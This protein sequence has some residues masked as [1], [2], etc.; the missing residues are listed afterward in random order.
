MAT[1]TGSRRSVR[2]ATRG[3]RRSKRV[4]TRKLVLGSNTNTAPIISQAASKL[5][6]SI[7][8]TSKSKS[9]KSR[10]SKSSKA[11]V[12]SRT[13]GSASPP[14][15]PVFRLMDLPLELRRL[16]YR[17]ALALDGTT[18]LQIC[19]Q[20]KHEGS[21]FVYRSTYLRFLG[22]C[23][24][25]LSGQIP[26]NLTIIALE[27]IQ[28]I[29]ITIDPGQLWSYRTIPLSGWRYAS[30]ACPFVGSNTHCRQNCNITIGNNFGHSLVPIERIP[31]VLDVLVD[32]KGFRHL[33][34]TVI[35]GS[36]PKSRRGPS[37]PESR[38]GPRVPESRWVPGSPVYPYWAKNRKEVY[39]MARARFAANYGPGVW[40]GNARPEH[41]YL[42][43]HPR[44][45][46]MALAAGDVQKQS[47][48]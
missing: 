32:F 41:S 23:Q 30:V 16:I 7:S 28:N 44:A 10:I 31:R 34:F 18:I 43:F 37:L 27:N 33:F 21:Q 25:P 29:D 48:I 40:H 1:A 5:R 24:I 46:Q 42:E 19:Q 15:P 39:E 38:R 36:I 11:V 26:L 3:L 4:A 22:N 9:S 8:R 35:W 6:T 17:Q 12:K 47:S 13:K 2:L 20:I 45:F 14:K